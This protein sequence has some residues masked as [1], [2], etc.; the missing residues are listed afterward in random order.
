MSTVYEMK[1]P[2]KTSLWCGLSHG[3]NEKSKRAYAYRKIK[4]K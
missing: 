3:N 1:E 2:T 4:S